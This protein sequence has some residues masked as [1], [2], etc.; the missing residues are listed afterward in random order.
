MTLTETLQKYI[1]GSIAEL[2]ENDQENMMLQIG[3]IDS[4]LRDKL[5]YQSFCKLI[6][7]HQLTKEQLEYLLLRL[8]QDDYLFY[9]IGEKG[10]DSVFTRAFSVLV[11][12]AIIEYDVVKL[13]L[14]KQLIE[15]TLD[16]VV[17]Y[18]KVEKDTRGYVEGKGWAHAIAHGA[19]ALD[20]LAKHPYFGKVSICEIL[21]SIKHVLWSGVNYL[22]EEEERLAFIVSS[23]LSKQDAEK[24]LQIW[25]ENIKQM[26]EAQLV[27]S[28]G[29]IEA[30]HTQ[31]TVKNFLKAVYL[32]LQSREQGKE[33]CQELFLILER[34]MYL[35]E[36]N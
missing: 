15:Q 25:V 2:T 31:R 36:G 14:N 9:R 28:R 35:K 19:D 11:I 13:Q 17:D 21:Q 30:Y 5:I 27:D 22:D 4:D 3:D 23:L 29:S 34:W 24:E 10:T 6:F 12:A 16:Q 33:L 26:V 8:Q 18:M 1:E 7:S 32:I 20:A